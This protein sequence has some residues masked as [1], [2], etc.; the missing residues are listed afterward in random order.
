MKKIPE[1]F[2]RKSGCTK[3][4]I[5]RALETIEANLMAGLSRT[6]GPDHL[7]SSLSLARQFRE[8]LYD[9]S[10]SHECLLDYVNRECTWRSAITA[11]DIAEVRAVLEAGSLLFTSCEAPETVLLL[12]VTFQ[13]L[14]PNIPRGS[15]SPCLI[16]ATDAEYR[17]HASVKCIGPNLYFV[18]LSRN[19]IGDLFSISAIFTDLVYDA[20]DEGIRSFIRP[21]TFGSLRSTY[22]NS[23][24]A[25]QLPYQLAAAALGEKF[26]FALRVGE[27]VQINAWRTNF[28][29]CMLAFLLGH[30]FGHIHLG[31]HRLS[32]NANP[33]L[34][35]LGEIVDPSSP[36][37][38]LDQVD[39][40]VRKHYVKHFAFRHSCELHADL[41]G[42]LLAGN[43]AVDQFSHRDI[44]FVAASLV[45]GLIAW[46]DRLS[47]F[48][49]EYVDPVTLVSEHNYNTAPILLDVI[50]PQPGHPWGRTRHSLLGPNLLGSGLTF[51]QE[52]WNN[53]RTA[54]HNAH[55]PLSSASQGAF[56]TALF[57]MGTG[58]EVSCCLTPDGLTGH[59]WK[60]HTDGSCS[61]E[62][63]FIKDPSSF[64]GCA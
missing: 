47:Y 19:L 2:Q 18:L 56:A 9:S 42:A 17:P 11:S 25:L 49:R 46:M 27:N 23:E 28:Y 44:G 10:I 15:L 31:H 52:E 35:I 34:G 29:H 24:H 33:E 55:Y 5:R 39:A 22:D 41:F 21:F 43:V 30:E 51:T 7:G 6:S 12:C 14:L 63:E 61:V 54:L 45:L 16:I 4:Q 32:K 3:T 37:Y 38:Q 59:I 57:V 60:R 53:L 13:L 1:A 64:F 48:E 26:R 8:L 62:T 36:L 50:R 58:R 20:Q 40:S